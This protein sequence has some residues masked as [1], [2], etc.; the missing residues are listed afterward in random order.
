MKFVFSTL[1]IIVAGLAAGAAYG[2]DE[3]VPVPVHPATPPGLNDSEVGANC[4]AESLVSSVAAYVDHAGCA[5]SFGFGIEVNPNGA[6]SAT[7]DG[8]TFSNKL[9]EPNASRGVKCAVTGEG[10]LAGVPVRYTGNHAWNRTRT[11]FID[12]GFPLLT[13]GKIPYDHHSIKDYYRIGPVVFDYGLQVITKFGYPRVKYWQNSRYR[14]QDGVDGYWSIT[15][16]QIT[17]RQSCHISFA[18]SVLDNSG[19]ALVA[20]G[21]ITAA[22]PAPE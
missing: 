9:V 14:P 22:P 21:A 6:G 18:S 19:G 16:W 10:T 12:T 2:G 13:E 11:I 8:A 20:S 15:K 4:L 7:L 5:A 17:P 3:Q 1:M